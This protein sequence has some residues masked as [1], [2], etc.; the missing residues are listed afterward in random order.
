MVRPVSHWVVLIALL[1]YWVLKV[2]RIVLCKASMPGEPRGGSTPITTF[3][4]LSRMTQ[5]AV[6]VT[7]HVIWFPG[8]II[9]QSLFVNRRSYS[10]RLQTGP[11]I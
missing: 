2:D 10:T 9:L 4:L 1:P 6:L 7:S 11:K 5:E 3:Q 8:P